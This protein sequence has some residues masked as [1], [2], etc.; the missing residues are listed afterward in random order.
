MDQVLLPEVPFIERPVLADLGH[1]QP[2]ERSTSYMDMEPEL[3][4]T[5]SAVSSTESSP[6]MRANSSFSL[7][8]PLI[9][10]SST[11]SVSSDSEYYSVPF[12]RLTI[13]DLLDSFAMGTK[14]T[15]SINSKV[16]QKGTEF[17]SMALRQRDRVIGR[18]EKNDVETLRASVLK[19]VN[20]LEV[21]LS[22]AH[23]IS[24]TEKLAFSLSLLNLFYAGF[25][26]GSHPEYFHTFY[27]VEL[28]LLLPI[29]LYTYSK[30]QYHYFLADL[31]YFVNAQCLVYIWILP[32]SGPLF[33]SCYALSFGTLSWAVITWR[34]SLVLHSIEKT[35]TSFI[36]LLPPAVF[37]V[38][39]HCLDPEYKR[40]RFSGAMKAEQWR[41]LNGVL[42][43]S[44]TYLI[45]QSLYHYFITLK[46]QDK[47]KSG[48]RATS[49]EHLRKS[50]SKTILG[51]FVNG[52]P[53]PFPVFAFT[54]IQY[55]YQL[56]TMSL[57]PL[58]YSSK[59]MSS[60]FV[61]FIFF[62]A[63]YNGATYYIDIF[64]KKFQKELDQLQAEVER[65]GR[66]N[67]RTGSF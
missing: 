54:L 14:I 15:K 67:V 1:G 27:T 61:T 49:F 59:L 50:Y 58:W 3:D 45:W 4:F 34:N 33:I 39:T 13:L 36:H 30:K 66:A 32:A 62:W 12:E 23:V 63:A 9:R 41:V 47:I 17:K 16:R 24:T 21:R 6:L 8:P 29:R 43:A 31:C 48:L 25:I 18:R 40:K 35:T 52:L 57:C 38:I 11:S 65:S 2:L 42:W 51:R 56:L 26:I 5:E 60:L 28:G 64:G 55:G 10:T 44:V 19:R 37:H 53:E 46:R 20:R 22:S 7:A